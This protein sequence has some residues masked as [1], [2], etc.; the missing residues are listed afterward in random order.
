MRNKY[1][2]YV[3]VYNNGTYKHIMSFTIYKGTYSL[4]YNFYK[5]MKIKKNGWKNIFSIEKKFY[6][7][8]NYIELY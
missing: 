3:N 7:V 4:I 5:W 8:K 2:L 1:L 6:K